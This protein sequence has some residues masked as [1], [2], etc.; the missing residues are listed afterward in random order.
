MSVI[1]EGIKVLDVGTFV[2]GPAAATVMSDFGAEVIKIENPKMGD[3]YR[4]LSQM[5]PMPVC[6]DN[7]CWLLDARNKK[8][9]ALNLKDDAARSILLKLVEDADVFLTNYPPAV[10]ESLS[11][12]YGDIRSAKENIIYAHATGY[13]EVGPERDRPGYDATA[14]WARSGLM[15]AV[16]SS[17]SGRLP[18][19]QGAVQSSAKPR[20]A[21]WREAWSSWAGAS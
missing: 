8:S 3:P 14:W 13:G 20:A 11:I 16:R 15:D 12:T 21:R 2:F 9:V 7:Y 5:P 6:E 17:G 18:P 4:Y 1:L 10:V 19:R